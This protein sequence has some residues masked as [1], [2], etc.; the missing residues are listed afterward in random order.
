MAEVIIPNDS[1][2]VARAA[3]MMA[4]SRSR[5]EE[6]SLK[7]EMAPDVL[8]AAVDCGGEFIT[9]VTR[10]VERAVVAAKREGLIG[11]SHQ[12]EGA[13][14]GATHEALTQIVNKAIG[15]NIGGKIGIAKSGD[16]VVVAVFFGIGL[17]H[18]NEV[19]IALGH[20]VV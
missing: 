14:A 7:G 5:E 20:R 12:E 11:E 10:I 1:R 13:V 4:L 17:L 15:L 8:C 2:N 6:R 9:S 16:H 3:V 19:A 18:L